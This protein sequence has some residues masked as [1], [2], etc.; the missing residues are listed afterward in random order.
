[1]HI[2]KLDLQGFKSFPDRTSFHFAP[3]VSG[4]VGPNGCGKSNVVDAVKWCLGEQS[5]KSLRGRSMED[6]IF[7]GSQA[8]TAVGV[9]E[10]TLTFSSGD[11][12][13]P[14]EYARC[15]ELQITRRLFRDGASEYLINQGRVRLKDIQDVFRDTGAGN[16]LY[17]FIEQ[18][19]IGEIVKAKPEQRRTLIEEAAGISG[20]KA[21]KRE[22]ESRLDGTNRNLE[23]ATDLVED[24]TGRL[25][26]LK[27]QVAKATRYR[28]YRTE[29]RQGE[30]FLG[31]ARFS[32]LV[33]DRRALAERLRTATAEETAHQRELQRLEQG[34]SQERAEVSVLDEGVGRLRDRLAE[35]E[36]TRR[37]QESA[38][39][40]QGRESEQ[41][42][43]RI[44]R[45]EATRTQAQA[46]HTIAAERREEAEAERSGVEAIAASSQTT[47]EE[48][49][50]QSQAAELA[51][52]DS[53][54]EIEAGKARVLELVHRIARDKAAHDAAR[55]R[56]DDLSARRKDLVF[57]IEVVACSVQDS[58]AE[59]AT[60]EAT[61]QAVRG[62]LEQAETA[63]SIAQSEQDAAGT[64]KA[65]ATQAVE[66]ARIDHQAADRAADRCQTRLELLQGLQHAHEGVEDT[67]RRALQVP[68][69]MGTLADHLDVPAD[70]EELVATVLGAELEHVLVPDAK[71][72]LAVASATGARVGMLLVPECK[73]QGAGLAG[74]IPGSDV[75]QRALVKLVGQ[76]IE[77]ADLQTALKRHARDGGAYVVRRTEALP[78]ILLTQ[79]G[80]IHI[81]P[82]TSG[83]T[84][85]LQRRREIAD[86]AA[87]LPGL[88][89]GTAAALQ[90][91]SVAETAAKDARARWDAAQTV[92]TEARSAL[93]ELQ[94][95]HQAAAA[96]LRQLSDDQERHQERLTA[97]EAERD[98]LSADLDQLAN[99]STDIGTNLESAMAEQEQQETMLQSLQVAAGEDER[100][101]RDA[102]Q[103]AIVAATELAGVQERLQGL[104]RIEDTAQQAELGAS[105]QVDSC[106]R[107]IEAAHARI[108]S[109][110]TD[111]QRLNQALQEIGEE[112]GALR[113][114]IEE[115]KAQVQALRDGL[116]EAEAAIGGLRDAREQATAN[117]T[118]LAHQ[119]DQVKA[120]IIR[121]REQ[122]DERYQVS[123]AALLDR[124]DRNGQL[125]IEVPEEA[126]GPD[127]D[128]EADPELQA[129][130]AKLEV[131]EDLII[132]P[133]M[134]EQEA[135]LT[136]W[137]ER[138]QIARSRLERLGEVNLVAVQEYTEVKTR[139]DLLE[140]QRMDLEESVRAIRNSIAQLNR[141]CRER[142]RETF[143]R[144]DVLFREGY[145][146][147]VGGGMARLVLTDQDD[148][149]ETGVDIEVQPPG[150]RLQ[151]VSLLSGGEMAMAAISLIFA[152]F[153]VKPS[154]FCLLD[155]VDAPL[156]EANGARFNGLLREMSALSQFI[157][158]THNKK[159]M[160]CVDTLYGVTMNNPGV[161][162]LVTVKLD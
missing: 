43:A 25:R 77:V 133:A 53:R 51:L 90:V 46:D 17:S 83:G 66:A 101:F 69:V 150:K 58:Q 56:K 157:V 38:R 156:D 158:I 54:R 62:Q 97:L 141:T 105:R 123:V 160:E 72:A 114:R 124:L 111:D 136:E 129:T 149:L 59:V 107:D 11:E 132:T 50:Q 55:Q 113:T 40:Y 125:V 117:C 80:E 140:A 4:V 146:R 110:A 78:P 145:P 35:L 144:V 148:M 115:E 151:N 154:P 30:I 70:M 128:P 120:E 112:Q 162:K 45:L 64:T 81:G 6:V 14:G 71:T 7:A 108:G 116:K 147:L 52:N 86:L 106:S 8:R 89:A 48:A 41:L 135:L 91:Q 68:G 2:R 10:V 28:R 99:S 76:C 5:A 119:I 142:F 37:E 22:A 3:G 104:R 18:G 73:P 130:A 131:P 127:I 1:M 94:I 67:V 79:R 98:G 29:V 57:R 44:Q 49:A 137:I 39:I 118:D 74:V 65:A 27:R 88:Q 134:L 34:I 21:R 143:E 121:I 96:R 12:P 84:S 102:R 82:V 19:R 47:A 75:G 23:R 138:L 153:R 36:A 122:L 92:V 33:G 16:R 109:L 20:Y 126:I 161:S 31:L 13:F 139:F 24:L 152:L 9:A 100:R 26:S 85:V 60:A 159:T 61:A 42:Q 155:E 103:V 95:S 63:M 15:E 87:S 93:G 32:G